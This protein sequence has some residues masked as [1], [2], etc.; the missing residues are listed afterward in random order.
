MRMKTK[1][2]KYALFCIGLGTAV[3]SSLI[4]LYALLLNLYGMNVVFY[5]R[6]SSL[7]LFEIVILIISIATC[8][9]ASEIYYEYLQ[10]KIK[11]KH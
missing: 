1:N 11:A 5:E 6:N 4:C 7:A 10:L 2:M 9:V 8:F 3:A